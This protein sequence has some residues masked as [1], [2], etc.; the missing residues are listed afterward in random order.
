MGVLLLLDQKNI[1]DKHLLYRGSWEEEQLEQFAR[2]LRTLRQSTERLVFLDIGSHAALYPLVLQRQLEF[3]EIVAF[4]P[5]ASN[6]MQLRA[7]LLMNGSLAKVEIVE[8]AVSDENGETPFIVGADRNRGLSRMAD[9]TTRSGETFMN[10]KTIRLDD[11]RV[12]EGCMVAAKIDVEGAEMRVLHGMKRT[13]TSNR[14]VLQIE[15]H[16]DARDMADFLEA[17]GYRLL[18]TIGPDYF[19]A[20]AEAPRQ[21]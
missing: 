8:T 3:D 6:L 13:L 14:C 18:A 15:R 21:V 10:V 7:N 1:V 16:G 11:F 9:G 20:N 12:Y 4:E 5:V 2:T 17:L 19:Y